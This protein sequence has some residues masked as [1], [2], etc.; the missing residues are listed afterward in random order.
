MI[1]EDYVMRLIRQVIEAIARMAR[2]GAQGDHQAARRA[3]E[4]AYDLLGVPA[5]L[6]AALDSAA[7]AE[8]VGQP[9]KIRLLARVAIQEAE[10]L[11]ATGDPPGCADR[12]RRAAELILEARTRAPSDEDAGLLQEVFRHFSSSSLAPKYRDPAR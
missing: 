10:L 5:E 7:L 4:D 1:R 6:A 3:A 2:L 9:D 11:R 12:Y 8:L